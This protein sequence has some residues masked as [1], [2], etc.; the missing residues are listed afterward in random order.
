MG[1]SRKKHQVYLYYLKIVKITK[2]RKF[3]LKQWIYFDNSG[4]A[5]K[6]HLSAILPKQWEDIKTKMLAQVQQGS[7]FN[8]KVKE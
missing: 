6:L 7:R 3:R 1:F 5:K 2:R 4:H 8:I